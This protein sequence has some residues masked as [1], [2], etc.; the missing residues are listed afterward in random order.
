MFDTNK[1][2]INVKEKKQ[3]G[4]CF[5][6]SLRGGKNGDGMRGVLCGGLFTTSPR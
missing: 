4:C 3:D 6:Q 1:F 5:Q 2:E